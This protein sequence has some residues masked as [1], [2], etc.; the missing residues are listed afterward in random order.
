MTDRLIKAALAAADLFRDGDTPDSPAIRELIRAADEY[1]ALPTG[2]DHQDDCLMCTVRSLTEGRAREWNPALAG[3]SITGVVLS[4]G[5]QPTHFSGS[6]PFVELWLGG[7]DRRRVT[8]HASVLASL[9][10]RAELKV[11]DTLTV[12][13]T[14]KTP[15]TRGRMIGHEMKTYTSEVRRGHR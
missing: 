6:A 7:T 11:G 10:E 4:H 8:G 2:D 5:Y 9:I 13:Y 14:G 1:A 12:T 3:E 15:I